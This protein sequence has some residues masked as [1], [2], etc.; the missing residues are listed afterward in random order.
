MK[1]LD[2]GEGLGRWRIKKVW[3]FVGFGNG[4]AMNGERK[5]ASRVANFRNPFEISCKIC[6]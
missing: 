5:K 4:R 2:G 3:E 1:S 6:F